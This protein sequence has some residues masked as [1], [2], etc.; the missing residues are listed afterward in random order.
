MIRE[1]LTWSRRRIAS[2]LAK[3]GHRVD[4]NTVAKY[5][6]T[7]RDGMRIPTFARHQRGREMPSRLLSHG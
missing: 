2:E 6:P 1:N 7:F 4:K 5:M 3:L